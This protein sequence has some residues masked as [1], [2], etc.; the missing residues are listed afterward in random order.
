MTDG[1][2]H[3][4]MRELQRVFFAPRFWAAIA[5]ASVLAG[6][7]GPF[8]TYDALHLPGR[9]AYWAAIVVSTY[10]IGGAC[11]F[12]FV[13]TISPERMPNAAV[14]GL[15][16][17]IAGIPVTLAVWGINA[18]VFG[19][20]PA[21]SIPL[22]L[23]AGYTIVIA[24]IVSTLLAVFG[25]LYAEAEGT[26]SK[27]K[28]KRPRIL[29]RLP[30]GQRGVLSHMSMQDHYVDIRTT[31]GGGLVLM[32]FADAISETDGVAG[33]QIHRSHWVATDAVAKAVRRNGKL[34]LMLTDGTELPVSRSFQ[35]AAKD[36]GLLAR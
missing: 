24:A 16:G 12:L 6:L 1:P 17:A 29:D 15:A 5:G 9:V 27:D 25:R 28:R 10:F 3:F 32:R 19:G 14:F 8:G 23:L 11:V 2:L 26:P 7:I 21:S 34:F 22:L 13:R 33:V 18:V 20:D 30:P 35:P 31:K 36:A 4:T